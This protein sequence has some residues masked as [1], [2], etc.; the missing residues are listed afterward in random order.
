MPGTEAMAIAERDKARL[1]DYL[2]DRV[3]SGLA[4]RDGED[5]VGLTPSRALFAGVLLPVR[6]M[7][8]SSGQNPWDTPVG[9]SLGIDFRLR[10]HAETQTI[11]LRVRP[12]W[13]VYYPVFPRFEYV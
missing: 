13:S 1:A 8:G 4:G 10:P 6:E 11:R 3:L 2:L 12:R 9:T 5:L 7:G